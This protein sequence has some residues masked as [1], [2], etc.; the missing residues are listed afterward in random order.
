MFDVFKIFYKLN[1]RIIL[2]A[3]AV[4]LAKSQWILLEKDSPP[5]LSPAENARPHPTS[6]SVALWCESTDDIT[7]LLNNE[8]LWRYELR[9]KRWLWQPPLPVGIGNRTDAAYWTVDNMFYLY[10]G[11]DATTGTVYSDMWVYDIM[12]RAFTKLLD[13]SAACY[14]SAFWKHETTNHL[15][16]WGGCNTSTSGLRAYDLNNRAWT[17]NVPNHDGGN[18]KPVPAEFSAATL[19]AEGNVVYLYTDDKLWKLDLLQLTWTQAD[20]NSGTSPP[21]PQRT[22]HVLWTGQ[23]QSIM[24]YGGQA[25]G[26]RY[27]DTWSYH[28]DAW[29]LLDIGNGPS[30]RIGYTTCV[31]KSG[32]LVLFGG[33]RTNDLYKYGEITVQ[34]V[35]ELIE[36]KLDSATL[37]ASVAAVFSALVFFGLVVLALY[38]CVRRCVKKRKQKQSMGLLRKNDEEF[39]I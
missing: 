34:T 16:M 24:L 23:D 8:Q 21:G 5:L 20:T 33:G 30:A 3:L 38:L 39:E 31:D 19:A 9:N 2:I 14:G 4:T 6:N 17:E 29:K 13:R 7:Y 10:G 18:G 28:K 12:A 27:T 22:H 35:F 32:D 37:T 11:R 26:K 15:F 36:W 25:G 1:M